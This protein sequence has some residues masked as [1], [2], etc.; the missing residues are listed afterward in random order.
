MKRTLLGI[1]ATLIL[2]AACTLQPA[3]AEDCIPI[4]DTT[5]ITEAITAFNSGSCIQKAQPE[6]PSPDVEDMQFTCLAGDTDSLSRCANDADRYDTIR[7]TRDITTESL[8]MTLDGVQGLTFDGNGHTVTRTA[9]QRSCS[10]LDI[11]NSGDIKITNAV[12]DD[13]AR[14]APCAVADKCARMFH[15]RYSNDVVMD[16]VTIQN[17]KRYVIYTQSVDGFTFTNSVLSNSG[18][19]GLYVGH[20]STPST[21]IEIS[22]SEFYDNS[23]N[24]VALLG[25]NKALIKDNVFRRN[26]NRGQWPV[27]PQYGVGM[28]GGGQLYIARAM[29]VE[30]TGNEITDGSCANCLG[31]IHGIELSEPF[32][33]DSVAN[34]SITDN[35]INNNT[36]SAIYTNGGA[37]VANLVKSG[38]VFNGALSSPVTPT[39]DTPDS[40]VAVNGCESA[41]TANGKTLGGAIANF[42]AMYPNIKRED[43]DPVDG[44]YV[45]SSARIG[46]NSPSGGSTPVQPSSPPTDTSGLLIQ[47][48]DVLLSKGWNNRGNYVEWI[49]ETERYLLSQRID[50]ANLILDFDVPVAGLYRFQM[51]ARSET[52]F[53]VAEPG[54]D[55]WLQ[56]PTTGW[57][58][59]WFTRDGNW[60]TTTV[61]ESGHEKSVALLDMQLPAGK[62]RIIVSGRSRG[63]AID[64]FELVPQGFTVSK[65]TGDLLILNYDSWPDQDDHQ[66]VAMSKYIVDKLGLNPTV[67]I[68]AWG[69]NGPHLK[70]VDGSVE[71]WRSIYPNVL[72]AHNEK[73]SS[74]TELA[75]RVTA[76][77]RS[78]NKV[79]IAEGGPSDFTARMLRVL[80]SDV[81]TKMISVYQHSVGS[82]AFNES[83]TLPENLALVKSKTNYVAVPN[84]NVPNGSADFQ[85][86]KSSAMC[87][88][89]MSRMLDTSLSDQW[90]RAFSLIGESRQCDGSDT[91]ELLAIVGDTQTK[92]F[93]D[94]YERY[95][96]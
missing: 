52:I 6:L 40:N 42:T 31:G 79:S 80:P 14:D 17:G 81:D 8:C 54:N 41:C 24:A 13:D 22:Y 32:K 43:C 29:D 84:G 10:V 36:G 30:I 46:A 44:G 59:A 83:K 61:G 33:S 37:S 87:Q 96:K 67:V 66:A 56:H 94:F 49:G 53:N 5:T 86:P 78:G 65:T 68:G 11:V 60:Q 69:E 89:F 71:Y 16:N 63:T 82:T 27:S 45:C 38:N 9:N 88:R 18:V 4:S 7:L 50:A 74:A 92:T 15:V 55:I 73:A 1:A 64:W 48:E 51:R 95:V 20:G 2:L 75:R 90:L 23:T 39:V 62:N 58:K 26:H 70:F 28:T 19:L 35:V 91:V 3:H 72:D 25:A 34:V 76:T 12:F 57:L 47:A 85:E 77:I 21:N 93:D